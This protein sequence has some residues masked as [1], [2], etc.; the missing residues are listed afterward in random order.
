[1]S[2]RP[3]TESSAQTAK[4]AEI[5]VKYSRRRGLLDLVISSV[6]PDLNVGTAHSISSV[7]DEVMSG[8]RSHN[9]PTADSTRRKMPMPPTRGTGV[10]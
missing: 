3:S 7:T 2:V 8:C 4:A 1:M 9:T 6:N 5:A 10:A